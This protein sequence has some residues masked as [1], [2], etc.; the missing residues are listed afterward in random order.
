MDIFT[1][2]ITITN[3]IINTIIT[4]IETKKYL[5]RKGES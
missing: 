3:F 1:I 4:D 2:L 5:K